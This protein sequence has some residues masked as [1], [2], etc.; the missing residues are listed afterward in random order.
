MK[1]IAG[2]PPKKASLAL[3][4]SNPKDLVSDSAL[5]LNQFPTTNF[6]PPESFSTYIPQF[7]NTNQTAVTVEFRLRPAPKLLLHRSIEF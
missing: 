5:D 7:L 1:S 3:S 6:A 4:S 2:N